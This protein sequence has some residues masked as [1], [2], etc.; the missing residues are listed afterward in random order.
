MSRTCK[1]VGT[2]LCILG[3]LIATIFV[4]GLARDEG[5]YRDAAAAARSNPA[6]AGSV[7]TLKDAQI[8]R[9]FEA[10]G[11]I[12]GILLVINGST[13]LGLGMLAQRV[14]RRKSKQLKPPQ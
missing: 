14:P 2:V 6:D 5:G 12:V 11:V 3:M 13:L 8:R 7:T 10:V 4:V 9:A 1:I